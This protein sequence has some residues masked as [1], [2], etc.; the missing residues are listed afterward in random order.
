TA[1]A[2]DATSRT[3][4]VELQIDNERGELLPGSYAQVHF[5]L[6][7]S[8]NTLRVPVTTVLFRSAGLLVASV[9]AQRKVHLKS[10]TEGRDFGT[11][12]E[13]LSGLTP[14]DSLVLNPP[15]SIS[16]GEQVRIAETPVQG[17]P[18]ARS[19]GGPS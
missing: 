8:G 6:A 13:V 17:R 4:Q 10:I 14:E 9:D 15:D 11:E 3:L 12:I 5:T 18:A 7:S 16:E 19:P 1:H 2:L